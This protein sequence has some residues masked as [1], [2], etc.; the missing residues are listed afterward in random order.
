MSEAVDLRRSELAGLAHEVCKALELEVEKLGFED[1]RI[2]E[3]D[4]DKASCRL[5]SDTGSGEQSLLGEWR[6]ARGQMLGNFVFHADG[7]FFAEYDVVRAHPQRPRFFVEAVT[8]WG[9]HDTIKTE[10]RLIPYA[11]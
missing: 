1:G 4:F 10:P 7:S 6:D 5:E 9:R 8:A 3:V 11:G 2:I